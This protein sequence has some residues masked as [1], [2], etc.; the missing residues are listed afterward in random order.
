MFRAYDLIRDDP[1][2]VPT[3]KFAYETLREL[4]V[5]ANTEASVFS[6]IDKVM[7]FIGKWD[8]ERAKLPYQMDGLVVKVNDRK[9]F[10][11]LGVVGKQPRAAIAY[12]Y[13]AEEATTV[14]RD[15]VISIG[16]TGAATPVAVFDPVAVAG[17]TVR[18]AS[19]HNADEIARKD[20]RRGDTVVIFK[21]GEIIP[22]VDR[23]I[24]E[25]RPTDSIRI[26]FEHELSRQYPELRFERPEGDAIYRVVGTSS[27]LI[28]KRSLEHYASRVA[29]DIDGLGEKNVVAL[30]DSGLVKDLAGIYLVTVEDLLNLDRFAD[31]SARNL[32]EAISDKKSPPLEKFIFGLGIRHVG[33]QTAIDQ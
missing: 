30:V 1:S 27:D 15:I 4:G 31:L 3:N 28:L 23:V 8:S 29:L 9:L 16:R 13:P 14:V 18:H 24:L 5:V 2:E 7:E 17:T 26:D 19:L 6:S 22:Q 10:A 11:D 32:V 20:I 25:L 33:A 12:K 21:A